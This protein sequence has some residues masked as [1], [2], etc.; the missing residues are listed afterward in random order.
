MATFQTTFHATLDELC[1]FIEGWLDNHPIIISAFAFPPR[2]RVAISRATVREVLARPDVWEVTFT[3]GPVDPCRISGSD[4][5]DER[6]S[7]MCLQIGRLR[8]DGLEQSRLFC[9]YD[10]PIWKKINRGLKRRTTAGA[11]FTNEDTGASQ[12]YRNPRFT[13]GAKALH[14]AG[15]PLRNLGTTGTN[16]QPK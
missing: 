9:G 4:V 13:V 3:H 12:F 11:V 6:Q 15:T 10:D 5:A 1:E 7:Y 2:S 14:V 16:Y 8:P